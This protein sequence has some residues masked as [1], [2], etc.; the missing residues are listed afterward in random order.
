MLGGPICLSSVSSLHDASHCD[1]IRVMVVLV[2]RMLHTLVFVVFVSREVCD[3]FV[4]E[5]FPQVEVLHQDLLLALCLVL[6]CLSP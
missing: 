1:E 5:S 2:S 3:L 6:L 4:Q